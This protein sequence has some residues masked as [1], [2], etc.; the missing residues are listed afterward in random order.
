MFRF[1]LSAVSVVI[2]GGCNNTFFL[3]SKIQRTAE[4]SRA[5]CALC[6][7]SFIPFPFAFFASSTN[8]RNSSNERKH[9]IEAPSST[10]SKI[11]TNKEKTLEVLSS[12][13]TQKK[14]TP[15]FFSTST[16]TE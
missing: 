12:F 7:P 8:L 10:S 2:V 13:V 3:E 4:R 5:L 11:I 1:I 15:S 9:R 14:T 6:A 16:R